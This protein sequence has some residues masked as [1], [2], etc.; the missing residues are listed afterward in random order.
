MTLG[1][2]IQRSSLRHCGGGTWKFALQSPGKAILSG[3]HVSPLNF[4]L[5]ARVCWRKLC[6]LVACPWIGAACM[7]GNGRCK[8]N[9][10]YCRSLTKNKQTNI[11]TKRANLFLLQCPLLTKLNF[12]P[13]GKILRIQLQQCRAGSEGW[14][15]SWKISRWHGDG[16]YDSGE[17]SYQATLSVILGSAL[18]AC[19]CFF[20]PI[21]YSPEMCEWVKSL[22]RVRLFAT[23]WTV[24][25]YHAPLSMG[26][27]RQEY[28]SCHCLLQRIFPTQGLNPGLLHCRQMLYR[29]SHLFPWNV[30]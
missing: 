16:V 6:C 8:Y 4:Q 19:F 13:A 24:A 3:G 10:T 1:Q 21:T 2:Q 26:F 17:L 20:S 29:L 18:F 25:A 22:G 14:I 27:S 12:V 5:A 9:C 7:L 30:E 11:G 28:W 15:W 23:P